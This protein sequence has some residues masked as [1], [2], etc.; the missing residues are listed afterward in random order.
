[1]TTGKILACFQGQ[2]PRRTDLPP[3]TRRKEADFREKQRRAAIVNPQ[4]QKRWIKA[5]GETRYSF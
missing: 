3:T 2:T 5:V 1:M 4:Q